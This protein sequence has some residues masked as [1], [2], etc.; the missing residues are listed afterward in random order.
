MR[1]KVRERWRGE[2]DGKKEKERNGGR[3][4]RRED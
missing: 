1:E 3:W 4:L 2:M